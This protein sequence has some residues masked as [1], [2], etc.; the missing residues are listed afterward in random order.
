[1]DN[2]KKISIH[3][4][5]KLNDIYVEFFYMFRNNFPLNIY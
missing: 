3:V 5:I 1:M 4:S 2:K